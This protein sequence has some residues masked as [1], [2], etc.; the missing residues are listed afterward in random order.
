MHLVG[1]ETWF[2]IACLSSVSPVVPWCPTLHLACPLKSKNMP[3]ILP[4][5][6]RICSDFLS[7]L[8]NSRSKAHA[9][10]LLSLSP[11]LNT[12]TWVESSH[13]PRRTFPFGDRSGCWKPLIES[14][15]CWNF[16]WRIVVSQEHA[17]FALA[18]HQHTLPQQGTKGLT[19]GALPSVLLTLCGVYPSR[20]CT[21]MVWQP[22]GI[23]STA[24]SCSLAWIHPIFKRLN[25]AKF[26]CHI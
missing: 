13:S 22:C 20:G 26:I 16:D 6:L 11:F 8:L 12:G 3:F 15:V 9:W 4:S 1:W 10:E 24:F 14:L 21:S 17:R 7:C 5:L 23:Y 2:C 19:P 25:I 18:S